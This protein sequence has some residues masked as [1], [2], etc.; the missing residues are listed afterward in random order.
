MRVDYQELQNG[1]DV[2]G[3]ACEGIAGQ[4]VNLT[5]EAVCNIARAFVRWIS[6]KTGKEPQML[7]CGIGRDSRITGEKLQAA[8]VRGVRMEGAQ[9]TDCGLATTPAMF[10]GIV[11]PET[12]FDASVMLTASHLPF[13]RNG[14]KFFDQNG[15]LEKEDIRQ[16]LQ[17]AEQIARDESANETGS[18]GAQQ[19]MRVQSDSAPSPTFALLPLYASR[20]CDQIKK[21]V[22]AED[23]DH[24]LKGLRVV[25]D[26]GNGCGG[27]FC[28]QVLEPLG[29]ETAGYFLDPDGMFPNHIPNPEDPKAMAAIVSEI[30]EYQADLG[31]IFD[32]DVDRMAA[33]L[34][35]GTRLNKD[36]MIAMMSAII[37]PENPGCTI[38]T[39]SV[40]SD[41]LTEFLE[42]KLGLKHF[43]FRRGYKNIIDK[44]KALNEDGVDC[45]LAM[46]T[47]GHGCMRE[48]YYLD[49]GAY[50]A[51][52]LLIAAAKEK[53]CGGSIEHLIAGLDEMFAA[54]EVRFSITKEPYR[55]YQDKV[56]AEF[57]K[58]ALDAGYHLP[59]SY[60]GIR[61]SFDGNPK[62]WLLL[63]ASLHDPVMVLNMEGKNSDQLQKIRSIYDDLTNG[64]DGLQ[65]KK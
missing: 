63:R 44:C 20:L 8:C 4:A 27:F 58:R 21:G 36:G 65:E 22:A 39:D 16:I 52:R 29:A 30:K 38:V 35:D 46:E 1:S 53:S 25:V 45:P 55:E 33:V 57:K 10:M 34:P 62:G 51:V 48:N 7:R 49:D 15:G 3:V 19:K 32:T 41:R 5:E 31:L 50:L 13:N 24:P 17:Q 59:E 40:T 28:S 60:E 47:S 11:Y 64:F 26:A 18:T 42:Q 14:M 2:R 54:D 61:I 9:V 6:Q 23:Y 12:K 37:A 56:L 43:R